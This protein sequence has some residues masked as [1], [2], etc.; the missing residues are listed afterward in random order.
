[1][2]QNVLGEGMAV[3]ILEEHHISSLLLQSETLQQFL[4][5]N[6]LLMQVLSA[7][8]MQWSAAVQQ[9]PLPACC[10][11]SGFDFQLQGKA[12]GLVILPYCDWQGEATIPIK[13]SKRGARQCIF[14]QAYKGE[15]TFK[16]VVNTKF[17]ILF[18]AQGE[19]LPVHRSQ[20]E[21]ADWATASRTHQSK[22][23]LKCSIQLGEAPCSQ[24]LCLTLV[25]LGTRIYCERW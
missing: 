6:R 8:V 20:T 5:N 4:D 23:F 14:R 16:Q 3:L 9:C 25:L 11:T 1:M 10:S 2:L 13:K 7:Q 22:D 19:F 17:L 24:D 12:P 18:N 21:K 15:E